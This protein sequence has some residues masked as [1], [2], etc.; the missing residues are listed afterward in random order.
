MIFGVLLGS[1]RGSVEEG[2]PISVIWGNFRCLRGFYPLCGW[3]YLW[4][5]GVSLQ[6]G[7]LEAVVG[8]GQG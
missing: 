1:P 7:R 3:G 6:Y 8:L 2:G 5:A 4:C